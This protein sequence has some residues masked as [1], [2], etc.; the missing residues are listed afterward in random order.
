MR[1]V[2]PGLILSLALGGCS[3]VFGPPWTPTPVVDDLATRVGGG[4]RSQRESS[5]A[6]QVSQAW[7]WLAPASSSAASTRT[8]RFNPTDVIKKLN[9]G[10]P[11]P[12][13][14]ER[15]APTEEPPV[16]A[17]IETK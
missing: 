8:T 5:P 14:G 12:S 13:E 6:P 2:I 11:P 15:T 10:Q 17:P 16:K 9:A 4:P 7:L 3:N 1:I